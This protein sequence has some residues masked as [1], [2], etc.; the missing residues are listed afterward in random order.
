MKK[1]LTS[2][3]S[4]LALGVVIGLIIASRCEQKGETIIETIV[5]TDTIYK[6]I[7]QP[8]IKYVPKIREVIRKIEIP[9]EVD[10]LSILQDYYKQ[11]VYADT[12]AIDSIG[13][14]FINDTISQNKIQNRSISWNYKIPTITKDITTTIT[15]YPPV[16]TELYIGGFV[17]AN[18]NKIMLGPS[19][20]I[21]SK[22][23]N[24]YTFG[25]DF[26]NKSIVFSMS[27]KIG[28]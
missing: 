26:M 25:Y 28:K 22:K 10:T 27:K 19:L 1:T 6:E 9:I 2:K 16:K 21:K 18:K 11:Y 4:I 24:M 7:V 5:K 20:A 8:E 23:K 3:I 14:T 12:I 13:F 17:G 15:K